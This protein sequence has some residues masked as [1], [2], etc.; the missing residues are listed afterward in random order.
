MASVASMLG[1]LIPLVIA[2]V[3]PGPGWI[4]AVIAISALG[5]LGVGLARTVMG[6]SWIWGP[7]LAAGGA[8]V[9]VVG[10]WIKIT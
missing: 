1:A 10:L 8:A 5:A 7:A 4:A 2:I 3:L 9:T 6:K